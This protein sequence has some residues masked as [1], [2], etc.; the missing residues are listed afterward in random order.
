[1]LLDLLSPYEGQVGVMV[2]GIH[3]LCLIDSLR[4][5][6]LALAGRDGDADALFSS[7][8]AQIRTLRSTPLEARHRYWW[9]RSLAWRGDAAGA[10]AQY[11]EASEIASSLAMS[12]LVLCIDRAIVTPTRAPHTN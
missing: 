10:A 12:N 4:A 7:S 8:L 11:R 5:G 1:V 3:L 2:T 9:G 6:L